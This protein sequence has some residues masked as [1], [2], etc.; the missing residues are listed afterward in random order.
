MM[1][2]MHGLQPAQRKMRV[3]LRSRNIGMAQNQLHA[4]QVGAVLHHVRRATVAQPVRAG[5][6]VRS[7]HQVPHPLP[8]QRHAPQREKQPRRVLLEMS[9]RA[10]LA[11]LLE[12]IR[13]R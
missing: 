3:N 6:D 11:L 4:A 8:R 2:A 12:L 1:C 10:A 7:L 5:V 9:F 13:A